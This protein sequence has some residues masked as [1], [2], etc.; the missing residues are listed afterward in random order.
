MSLSRLSKL[1]TLAPRVPVLLFGAVLAT[2]SMHAA[3]GGDSN[4]ATYGDDAE[5]D[6]AVTGPEEDAGRTT[7]RDK[8]ASQTTQDGADNETSTVFV[9][10]TDAE[11]S[12][13]TQEEDAA[14][15]RD[16]T[17][18]DATSKDVSED[19]K[20]DREDGMK[21]GDAYGYHGKK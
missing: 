5:T 11:A 3:C 19:S 12:D 16:A 1:A 9:P 17:S 4:S 2:S 14:K 10:E 7:T 21:Y 15:K 6:G 18:K 8:D 13:A 20:Q